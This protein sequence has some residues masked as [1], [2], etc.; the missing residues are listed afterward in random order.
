[1]AAENRVERVEKACAEAEQ[2]ALH[3]NRA[4]SSDA[5]DEAAAGKGHDEREKLSLGE[6]LMEQNN[7]QNHD[8]RGRG[9]KK[10]R[11]DVQ[12]RNL[13]AGK[14]AQR[15]KKQTHNARA[16]K[17]PEVLQP[18]AEALAGK[19]QHENSHEQERREHA[20]QHNV[21]RI[22]P[23]G[24]QPAHKKSHAAPERARE[25]HQNCR[26]RL[27]HIESSLSFKQYQYTRK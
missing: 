12:A 25:E 20:R 1:M 9:I 8:D 19:E 14:I 6:L 3:R 4:F 17:A 26:F 5:R 23:R 18:D 27:F 21:H 11:H 2:Q 24:V 10:N 7:A 15:K 22:K 13:H 16:Q